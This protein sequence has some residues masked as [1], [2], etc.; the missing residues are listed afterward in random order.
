VTAEND[1]PVVLE[2]LEDLA[3]AEHHAGERVLR[4]PNVEVRHLAQEQV[5]PT[6]QGSTAGQEDSAVHD[7]GGQLGGCALQILPQRVDDV[8]DRLLQSLPDLDARDAQGAGDAPHE[9]A[10][11]D[12]HV[13]LF[14]ERKRGADLDLDA[15]RGLLTDE[16]VIR[17]LGVVHD[18]LVHLVAPDADGG[19][20]HDAVEG[21]H[22]D[23]G[24]AAADVDDHVAG[25]RVDRKADADG[26]R[27][28]LRHE[29]HRLAATGPNRGVDHRP[30]LHFGDAGGHADDDAR[31][32]EELVLLNLLHEP[33]QQILGDLEVGDHAVLEGPDG[34]DLIRRAAEHQLGLAADRPHPAGRL[35]HRHDGGF[36]EDD[37]PALHEDQRVRGAQVH[38]HVGREEP[39]QAIEKH[40][41]LS[42]WVGERWSGTS[43]GGGKSGRCV[44]RPF[45]A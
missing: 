14:G 16:H 12:L 4:H 32:H 10:P 29:Q 25:R 20:G 31:A 9:V 34:V 30:L 7:I 22:G 23:L 45:P 28:R 38:G 21:D 17:L 36:V 26:R 19:L 33:A 8:A 35:V 15:L 2:V 43:R 5:Q 3:G 24:G 39:H 40:P 41:C 42:A 44:G 6:Q 27:D 13:H 1:F 37:A 11:L 18:R